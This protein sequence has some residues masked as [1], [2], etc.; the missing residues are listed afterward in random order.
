MCGSAGGL[1]AVTRMCADLLGS[2]PGGP[3]ISMCQKFTLL[4]S[5]RI[6]RNVLPRGR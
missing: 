2:I 5:K 1:E 3:D 4:G 6:L